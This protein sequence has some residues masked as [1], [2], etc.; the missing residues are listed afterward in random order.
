MKSSFAEFHPQWLGDVPSLRWSRW[1]PEPC[2][3]SPFPTGHSP[4]SGSAPIGAGVCTKP[5]PLD[6]VQMDRCQ[7]GSAV[8][9]SDPLSND[10]AREPGN[11]RSSFWC[12]PHHVLEAHTQRHSSFDPGQIN[13]SVPDALKCMSFL[14]MIV[15]YQAHQS[16]YVFGDFGRKRLRSRLTAKSVG[17]VRAV[18]AFMS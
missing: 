16:T 7:C 17:M 8:R 9:Q 18:R 15:A 6:M 1:L 13:R 14:F 3:Y 10:Y 2:L 5:S 4:S 11:D 12:I